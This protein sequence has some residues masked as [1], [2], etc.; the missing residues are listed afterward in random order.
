M[1]SPPDITPEPMPWPSEALTSFE[2]LKLALPIPLALGLP[3]FDKPFHPSCYENNGIAAGI[4]G[5]PFSS[6][7]CPITYFLCQLDPSGM[8]PCLH[9][10][11]AVATLIDKASTLTLGSPIHLSLPHAVSAIYKFIGHS[12]SLQGKDHL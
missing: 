12:T 7:I 5:Q 1:C 8:P 2:A 6:Q 4:L 9:A 3:N 11:A 10:V